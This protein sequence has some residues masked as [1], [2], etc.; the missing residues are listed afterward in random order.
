MMMVMQCPNC[1]SDFNS[2]LNLPRIMV[3]C[4]HTFCQICIKDMLV[5]Q[6]EIKSEAEVEET[7]EENG[8]TSV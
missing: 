8:A 4:G 7:D 1:H 5:D 2:E 6:K 3:F